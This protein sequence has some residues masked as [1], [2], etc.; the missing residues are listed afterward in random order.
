MSINQ[1]SHSKRNVY[2]EKNDK[3]HKDSPKYN[4]FPNYRYAF[5]IYSLFEREF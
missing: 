1:I 2:E 4:H 5:M 3:G